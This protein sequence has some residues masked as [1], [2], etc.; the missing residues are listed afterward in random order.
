MDLMVGY[1]TGGLIGYFIPKFHK[2]R[3]KNLDLGLVPHIQE[4]TPNLNLQF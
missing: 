2:I 3:N 4:I 1:V